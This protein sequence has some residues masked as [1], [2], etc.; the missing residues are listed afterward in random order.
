MNIPVLCQR[1]AKIE[2]TKIKINKI[3]MRKEKTL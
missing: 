2:F 3:K 1:T